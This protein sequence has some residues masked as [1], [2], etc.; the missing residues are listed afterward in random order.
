ME[1]SKNT[2]KNVQE[3]IWSIFSGSSPCL[4]EE[5]LDQFKIPVAEFMP[6]ELIE[7][8]RGFVKLVFST[9]FS[10]A[11]TAWFSLPRIIDQEDLVRWPRKP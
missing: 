1:H 3:V 2:I 4:I 11:R 9:A 6:D 10:I 7:V 5:R 8:V